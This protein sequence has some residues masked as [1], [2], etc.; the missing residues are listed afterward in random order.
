M[1]KNRVQEMNNRK[2]HD[3]IVGLVIFSS[4]LLGYFGDRLWLF[5]PA[6]LGL[7]LLQSAVT[8]FCPLYYVLDKV[9]PDSK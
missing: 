6:V 1:A 2:I 3:G 9:H 5:V 7:V 8:G 4:V